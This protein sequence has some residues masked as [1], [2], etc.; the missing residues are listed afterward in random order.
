M[1][2]DGEAGAEPKFL[3][4]IVPG[5][6]V[7]EVSLLTGE[8]RSASIQAI[9]DSL[10]VKINRAMFEKLVHQHPALVLKLASNVASVLHQS[11]AGTQ[12]VVRSLN[13]ITLLPLDHSP[14]VREFCHAA[15]KRTANCQGRC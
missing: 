5:D 7:G 11:T 10:L 4:E 8:P 13:T 3:G 2:G 12:A 1:N 14:R 9:R 15:R 6:S